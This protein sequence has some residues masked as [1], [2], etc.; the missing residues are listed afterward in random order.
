MLI[1]YRVKKLIVLALFSLTVF[2]IISVTYVRI[3]YDATMR[4][5]NEKIHISHLKFED[6]TYK[7]P[8]YKMYQ[9][10]LAINSFFY[11]FWHENSDLPFKVSKTDQEEF[12]SLIE[13]TTTI[14]ASNKIEYTLVGQG[15]LDSWN[16]WGILPEKLEIVSNHYFKEFI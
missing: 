7:A 5:I 10:P 1:N 4:I 11:N 9:K 16:K 2:K 3:K 12:M 15:L 6:M 14:F 13:K 8:E